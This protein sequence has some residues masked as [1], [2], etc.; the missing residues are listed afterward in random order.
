MALT[1]LMRRRPAARPFNSQ[2]LGLSSRRR[3]RR[4]QTPGAAF[5]PPAPRSNPQALEERV[6]GILMRIEA[7]LDDAEQAIGERLHVIDLDNDG[8]I[9]KEELQEVRGGAPPPPRALGAPRPCRL[10]ALRLLLCVA[11]ACVHPQPLALDAVNPVTPSHPR[12]CG[13]SRPTWTRRTCSRS[14]KSEGSDCALSSA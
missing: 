2:R 6:S 8:L 12:P 1:A 3:R 7:E 11:P 10:S 5:K 13:S 14:W 4:V 9:S